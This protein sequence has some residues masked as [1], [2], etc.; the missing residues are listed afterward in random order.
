MTFSRSRTRMTQ[1]MHSLRR[2][3]GR[4]MM[5]RSIEDY[6]AMNHLAAR[7]LIPSTKSLAFDHPF[8]LVKDTI[9]ALIS[10]HRHEN[11]QGHVFYQAYF[12]GYRGQ[13]CHENCQTQWGPEGSV[14]AHDLNLRMFRG[15][16]GKVLP[17]EETTLAR[18]AL[19]LDRQCLRHVDSWLPVSGPPV[20]PATM[21]AYPAD[22]QLEPEHTPYV[23]IH[24][25][26]SGVD[27]QTAWRVLIAAMHV[28]AE[29]SGLGVQ[30]IDTRLH[31]G[32]RGADG[33]PLWL[34]E[35]LDLRGLLDRPI[36]NPARHLT[37]EYADEAETI[38]AMRSLLDDC[39][40]EACTDSELLLA[41]ENPRGPV[42]LGRCSRIQVWRPSE[43]AADPGAF[44]FADPGLHANL[45]QVRE[46]WQKQFQFGL[47]PPARQAA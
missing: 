28:G 11:P 2:R 42:T 7:V 3:Q 24:A 40:N 16:R 23:A 14:F 44:V 35:H 47:L 13:F 9:V 41:L 21:L 19:D 26:N 36:Y 18:V 25:R 4:Q 33:K 1:E 8:P 5:A 31:T 34:G 30:M 15:A 37:R 45:W 22:V 46:T 43:H 12:R 39:V 10:F 29:Q 6:G 32:L 17:L 27:W 20:L 38:A